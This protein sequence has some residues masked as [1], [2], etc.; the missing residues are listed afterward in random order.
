MCWIQ[1]HKTGEVIHGHH[2]Q[3][4]ISIHMMK[5]FQGYILEIGIYWLDKGM[6]LGLQVFVGN[7]S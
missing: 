4:D 3:V 6:S 2:P 1:I 5:F 7:Y